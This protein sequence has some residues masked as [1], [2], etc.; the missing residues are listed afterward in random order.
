MSYVTGG[1]GIP[2]KKSTGTS[3]SYDEG[4]I[5]LVDNTHE[6][7]LSEVEIEVEDGDTVEL[8]DADDVSLAPSLVVE[9][10]DPP[11]V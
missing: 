9:Q 8:T 11:C 2:F 6:V 4:S 1:I 10:D 7:E 5:E 3:V